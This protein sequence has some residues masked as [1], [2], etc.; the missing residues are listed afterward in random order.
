MFALP[1]AVP[2]LPGANI[3]ISN[4]ILGR[5]DRIEKSRVDSSGIKYHSTY[6]IVSKDARKIIP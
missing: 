4:Q 3:S 2:S 6:L 1:C 5:N